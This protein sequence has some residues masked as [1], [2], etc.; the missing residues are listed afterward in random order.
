[1]GPRRVCE[2]KTP[3]INSPLDEAFF[4]KIRRATECVPNPFF[5]D[6]ISIDKG[7]V[8]HGKVRH[9]AIVSAK[10]PWILMLSLEAWKLASNPKLKLKLLW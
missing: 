2:K 3:S 6:L 10:E 4:A 9:T 5:R 1:M 7:R 8:C